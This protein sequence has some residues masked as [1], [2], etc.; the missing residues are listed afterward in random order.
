MGVAVGRVVRRRYHHCSGPRRVEQPLAGAG[1]AAVVARLQHGRPEVGPVALDEVRLLARPRIAGQ[2]H[3]GGPVLDQQDDAV[4]VAVALDAARGRREHAHRRP[5]HGDGV[6]G[7]RLEQGHVVTLDGVEVLLVGQRARGVAG[8]VDGPDAPALG[9]EVLDDGRV[10]TDV[11]RVGV[12][13]HEVV[14]ALDAEPVEV[15]EHVLAVVAVAPRV[16]EHRL[17]RRADDEHGRGLADVHEVGFEGAVRGRRR[18]GGRGGGVR[19]GRGRGVR[20]GRTGD[21]AT[22][23]EDDE[24]DEGGREG[25]A[26]GHPLQGGPGR[27]KRRWS[28]EGS[29]GKTPARRTLRTATNEEEPHSNGYRHGR[30]ARPVQI[31]PRSRCSSELRWVQTWYSADASISTR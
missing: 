25:R 18:C 12:G 28:V 27:Q 14:E 20:P 13:R 8:V 26:R 30:T 29:S 31:Q 7:L 9:L 22:A 6:A 19:P 11:V 15:R 3:R 2:Q 23:R 21:E 1:P 24:G 17:A 5:L 16:H 10:A 4:L